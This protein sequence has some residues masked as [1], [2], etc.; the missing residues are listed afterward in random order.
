[1]LDEFLQIFRRAPVGR[2]E[3]GT[4]LLLTF[5]ATS[6][7]S[8]TPDSGVVQPFDNRSRRTL[9][10]EEAIPEEGFEAGQALLLRGGEVRQNGRS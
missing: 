2:Y 3:F 8:M 4:D 6:G 1:M 10:Q 9:G 5:P 7:A